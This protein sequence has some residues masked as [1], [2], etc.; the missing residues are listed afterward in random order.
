MSGVSLLDAFLS[1]KM[2]RFRGIPAVD[3]FVTNLAIG[4]TALLDR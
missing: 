2:S 4:V 3:G 1:V